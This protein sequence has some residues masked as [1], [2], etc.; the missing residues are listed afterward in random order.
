MFFFFEGY[1]FICILPPFSSFPPCQTASL[2]AFVFA[3]MAACLRLNWLDCDPSLK[4][5]GFSASFDG[6]LCGEGNIIN[7]INMQY[8]YIK[9]HRYSIYDMAWLDSSC[10]SRKECS[11]TQKY[12]L[13]WPFPFVA[14]C[15]SMAYMA[16]W[17]K[18]GG[19]HPNWSYYT[20]W[21]QQ[22]KPPK[23]GRA[24]KGKDRI[25]TIH[26]QGRKC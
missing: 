3:A 24:P 7:V 16:S 2:F 1:E 5:S 17:F 15:I 18:L 21:N 10:F 6:F 12:S 14:T 11:S 25:P 22:P 23:I 19:W 20:P 13:I 9:H 4:S 26:F 8:I